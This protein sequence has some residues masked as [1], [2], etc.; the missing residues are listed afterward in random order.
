[1]P[2]HASQGYQ[3]MY[4]SQPKVLLPCLAALTI[5]FASACLNQKYFSG[6][7]INEKGKM[8]NSLISLR[9]KQ[10]EERGEPLFIVSA[11][12]FLGSSKVLPNLPN[13]SLG[14]FGIDLSLFDS[15]P[16]YV[17]V[18]GPVSPDAVIVVENPHSFEVAINA[19]GQADKCAWVS[20]YG[21]GLSMKTNPD[22]Y[23]NQLVD[24]LQKVS[25]VK[26]L[27]RGGSPQDLLQLVKHEKIH[28]WGDLD[29]EGLKIYHRLKSVF[30]KIQYSALYKPM[31]DHIKRGEGHPYCRIVSKENQKKHITDDPKTIMLQDFCRTHAVDQEVVSSLDISCLA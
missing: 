1:M 16:R 6:L 31:I 10:L 3:L 14:K 24:E 18:A 25:S 20:T 26:T 12:Y 11:K 17:I 28:L 27:V 30:P 13:N 29:L 2:A 15:P 22:E 19:G 8:L 4:M 5:A 21:Y 9:D 7:S 23:G